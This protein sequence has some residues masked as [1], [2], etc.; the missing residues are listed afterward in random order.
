MTGTIGHRA[1]SRVVLQR[2]GHW[3]LDGKPLPRVDG[4]VDIDLAFT[5]A[6]NL[7]PIRR[8][9]LKVGQFANVAAAWL[10]SPRANL[11]PLDQTYVRTDQSQ[12][13]YRSG[14]FEATLTVD[15]RGFVEQ[16]GGLWKKR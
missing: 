13:E 16:Y 11:R 14:D 7:L 10:P 5:P 9:K 15:R 2:E 4:C 3:F 8:L 1:I 12:Y 6:T